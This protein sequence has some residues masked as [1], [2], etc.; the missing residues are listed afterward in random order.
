VEAYKVCAC[1][2]VY[3]AAFSRLSFHSTE[4]ERNG[5]FT[6][7][8]ICFIFVMLTVLYTTSHIHTFLQSLEHQKQSVDKW[9]A[10]HASVQPVV[11]LHHTTTLAAESA[12]QVLH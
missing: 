2:H 10:E 6:T 12:A 11:I 3:N 7:P 1:V 8:L 9:I 5:G 4:R